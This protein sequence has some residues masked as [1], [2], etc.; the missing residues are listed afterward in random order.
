VWCKLARDPETLQ[1][2]HDC[3]I[4]IVALNARSPEIPSEAVFVGCDNEG[5]IFQAVDHLVGLGHRH[6]AFLNE[7]TEHDTPDCEARRE[8]FRTRMLYHGQPYGPENELGWS[9][10]MPEFSDWWDTH[11]K[12]TAIIG[13]SER[14]AAQLL[15][16]AKEKGVRVPQELS[17]VGFDSTP[18]S[19]IVS[20][21]LTSVSQPIIEM[22]RTAGETLMQMIAGDRPE[23]SA[24]VLPC[25]FDLRDSTCAPRTIC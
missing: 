16:C 3:P 11:P 24:I 4:P 20:P 13:W 9:W 15:G 8:G 25:G 12:T 17:V 5:G 23:T 6:I 19:E 7:N 14:C 18:Y 2:I 10:F 21:R 1:L 22:A